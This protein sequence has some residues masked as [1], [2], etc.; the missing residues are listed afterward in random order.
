MSDIKADQELQQH[1]R[2]HHGYDI[3]YT[4]AAHPSTL[5]AEH[6]RI[7]EDLTSVHLDHDHG[8]DSG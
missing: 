4:V 8:S 2:R 1:L 5:E 3:P 6:K 7:H